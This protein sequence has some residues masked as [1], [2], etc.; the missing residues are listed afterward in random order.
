M[1]KTRIYDTVVVIVCVCECAAKVVGGG[2]G[3]WLG[4]GCPCPPVRNDGI[5]TQCHLLSLQ[6]PVSCWRGEPSGKGTQLVMR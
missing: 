2:V 5:V 3:V 1:R 4:V 6:M